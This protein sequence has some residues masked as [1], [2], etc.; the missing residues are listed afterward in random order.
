M[1]KEQ[2][3]VA[4]TVEYYRRSDVVSTFEKDRY[5]TP[6]GMLRYTLHNEM[7]KELTTDIKEPILEIA[8]GTGRFTRQFSDQ[9][10]KIFVMDASLTMIKANKE[11][12]S[13]IENKVGFAQ[14]LAQNLP[15][16][17]SSFGAVFCVDMFSHIA[18]PEVIIKEMV[19]VLKPGGMLVINFTNKSSLMGLGASFVSNPLRKLLGKLSVYANYHWSRDFLN[20]ISSSGMTFQRVTGLFFIDPRIYRFKFGNTLMKLFLGIERWFSRRNCR[21]LYEQVWI[22]AIKNG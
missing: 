10:R 1:D 16:K 7:F 5:S 9:R 19:R 14:G 15:F 22:K 4:D 21:F 13:V 17:D 18:E 12:Q 3:K 2:V 20:H 6:S 8:G 11:N